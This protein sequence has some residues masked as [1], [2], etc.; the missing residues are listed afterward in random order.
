MYLIAWAVPFGMVFLVTALGV[1]PLMHARYLFAATLPLTLWTATA[2]ARLSS[3]QLVTALAMGMVMLQS[4]QQGSV[5]SW[6]TGRLPVVERGEHWREAIDYINRQ[7]ATDQPV[8]I[9][10]ASSL[11]EGGRTDYWTEMN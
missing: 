3:G 5:S 1:A 9:F 2:L 4:V 11:I 7:A 8:Q 10:C 6:L